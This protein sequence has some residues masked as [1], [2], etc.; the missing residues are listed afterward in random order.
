MIEVIMDIAPDGKV[1]T[2]VKGVKGSA[3]KALTKDYE[4]GLGK[5]ISDSTT[6]E[7]HEVEPTTRIKA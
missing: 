7:F 3:C 6:S 1:K 4:Q 2:T 5:I